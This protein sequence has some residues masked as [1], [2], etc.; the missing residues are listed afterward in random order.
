MYHILLIVSL[1]MLLIVSYYLFHKELATPAILFTLGICACAINLLN[2]TAVWDIHLHQNTF[3]L[4]AGGC[5]FLT[6]GSYLQ[7]LYR[8]KK[9]KSNM[10]KKSAK[11]VPLSINALKSLVL[12]QLMV[13]GLRMYFLTQYYGMGSL[14]EN[15]FAHTMAI[16]TDAD[17]AV[18]FPLGIGFLIGIT[19]M[20]GYVL[21]FLLSIYIRL[22]RSYKAQTFWLTINFIVCLGTSLLSSGRT[23]MLHMIVTFGVFYLISLWLQKKAL[24]AK[25]FF[26]WILL[27]FAFLACFQQIGFLI[28]RDKTTDETAKYVVGVYC[29]AQ[30]Q[31]LDDYIH[32]PYTYNPHYFGELTFRN[33][34]NFLD[35]DFKIV[36]LDINARDYHLFNN[37]RGYPLGNVAS[38][39]QE[40]YMDFGIYGTF[41]VCFLIGW[42]MQN[43]YSKVKTNGDLNTGVF[44]V[45]TYI[46]A[47]IIPSMFMSFF[48]ESFFQKLA[49]LINYRFWIGY[50]FLFVLI[51]WKI[52]WRRKS[53]NI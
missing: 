21:A 42:I 9:H 4:V 32:E 26:T 30:L 25:R 48:A 39:F 38:A 11:L 40:Y 51:Y 6:F 2:F 35:T 3:I 50:A 22:G 31:N 23:S 20:M 49:E 53:H 19:E 36:E 24:N 14:A 33:F 37:R 12:L 47:M 5:L 43:L 13:S 15:L 34:Y 7:Y 8:R 29:G 10:Q 27:A 41:V 1:I 17:S 45:S 44:S 16:K 28:G 52:P 18:H 46:F